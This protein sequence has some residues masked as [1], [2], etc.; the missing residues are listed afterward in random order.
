MEAESRVPKLR[1]LLG[2]GPARGATH[3]I[4]VSADDR[5][6]SLVGGFQAQ[7]SLCMTNSD[8]HHCHPLTPYPR[9]LSISFEQ[10]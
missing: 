8:N 7:G 3:R 1:V 10:A 9:L 4:N 6:S 2:W 5:C